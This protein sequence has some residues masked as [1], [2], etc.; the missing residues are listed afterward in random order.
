MERNQCTL[1]LAKRKIHFGEIEAQ[2]DLTPVPQEAVKEQVCA[3]VTLGET[4]VIPPLSELE[5]MAVV[6]NG[7]ITKGTWILESS[8][9]GP[10]LMV[11]RSIVKPEEGKVP[12]RLLNPRGE[13]LF[14]LL[15]EYSDIFA[16]NDSD[17]GHTNKVCHNIP[18]GN[19]PPIR[20]QLRRIPLCRRDEVKKLLQ[21]MRARQVIRPSNSPWA[22]PIVLVRKKDRS[23]RFC[24][25]YRKVNTATRK[26]AYPLPRVD[27][28]LDTLAGSKWFSTLDLISGYWQVEVDQKDREKTAFTTPEGLFEFNVM[29]FGLCNAPATLQRLMD[30][31]LA[32]LQQ[33]PRLPR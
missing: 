8:N 27:D 4:R 1:D 15:V 18:T 30:L 17:Y 23:T 10:S 29:P 20:Q 3:I 6:E 16:N 31:V 24:V 13:Q 14:T 2:V 21:D 5:V 9:L 26:D 32:G 28:T 25:D 33:L 11:A 19:S 7:N 12:G 22:A